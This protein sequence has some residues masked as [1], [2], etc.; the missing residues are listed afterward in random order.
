MNLGKLLSLPV[1]IANVPFRALEKTVAKLSG[2]SDIREDERVLSKPLDALAE[3][4][5][6]VGE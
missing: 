6:E 1:R 3:A 4:I 5:E 2:E